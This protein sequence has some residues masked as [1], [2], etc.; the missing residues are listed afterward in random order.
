[1]KLYLLI[2][3]IVFI[4]GI[5]SYKYLKIESFHNTQNI[6]NIIPYIQYKLKRNP[7]MDFLDDI[8]S[9]YKNYLKQENLKYI[10]NITKIPLDNIINNLSQKDITENSTLFEKSRDLD[11]IIHQDTKCT[12]KA[13]YICETTNPNFYLNQNSNFQPKSSFKPYSSIPLDKNINL[14]CWNTVYDCCKKSN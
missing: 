8:N 1:M 6:S 4:I 14:N 13:N 5:F 12:N 10:T 2:L 7:Y 9:T 11:F 3:I